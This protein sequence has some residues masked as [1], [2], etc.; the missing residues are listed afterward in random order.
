M[1]GPLAVSSAKRETASCI[2]LRTADSRPLGCERVIL[3]T[4]WGT[5]PASYPKMTYPWADS[6]KEVLVCRKVL[7][8]LCDLIA[9]SVRF[10]AFNFFIIRRT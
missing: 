10:F 2:S 1:D 7:K 4:I 3:A 9:T 6:S 8:T 5:P